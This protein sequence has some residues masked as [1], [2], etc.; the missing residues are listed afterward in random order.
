[1]LEEKII[2]IILKV[3]GICL[4]FLIIS[5]FFITPETGS[6]LETIMLIPVIPVI[7][8]GVILVVLSR[9]RHDTILPPY[10]RVV[11]LILFGLW[12]LSFFIDNPFR[13]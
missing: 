13:G 11:G 5:P 12:I 8:A 1:M 6:T 7:M 2:K 9:S 4:I 10:L 3:A